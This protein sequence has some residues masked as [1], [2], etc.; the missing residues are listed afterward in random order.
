[1]RLVKSSEPET[2]VAMSATI[3]SPSILTDTGQQT[4]AAF[5]LSSRRTK[6]RGH[7]ALACSPF[8]GPVA[9][10]E[11]RH[12][13]YRLNI[14]IPGPGEDVAT[15]DGR[16]SSRVTSSYRVRHKETHALQGVRAAVFTSG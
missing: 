15:M 6:Y 11:N 5:F 10:P 1:M 7:E 12:S 8:C 13:Q 9:C 16:D 14:D 3:L 4:R 2:D